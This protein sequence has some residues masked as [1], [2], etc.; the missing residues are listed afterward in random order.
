MLLGMQ[1]QRPSTW[2]LALSL[3][4][5]LVAYRLHPTS[6]GLWYTIHGTTQQE[7]QTRLG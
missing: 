3:R 6:A 7:P 4:I 2:I 1:A 5:S